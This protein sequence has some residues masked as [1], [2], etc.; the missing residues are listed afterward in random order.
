MPENREIVINTGPLIALVAT[1]G[2]LRILEYAYKRVLVPFEVATEILVENAG[3]FAAAEFAAASW[4]EKVD[5]PIKSAPSMETT[6]GTGEAAVIQWAL[7]EKIGL[8]GI[9][10]A[11][12]RRVARVSGLRVTG[13]LGILI[14]AKREG[15]PVLLSEAIQ[16]MRNKGIWLSRSLEASA[17]REAG[18]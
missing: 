3:R 17:L 7:A 11:V 4:L 16:S 9:D 10:E 2:N 1:V 13:T 15:V 18:E 5:K 8:V 12:G 6:L 14:R